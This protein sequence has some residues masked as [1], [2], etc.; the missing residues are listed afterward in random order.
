[1]PISFKL[2]D[3]TEFNGRIIGFSPYAI[4]ITQPNGV[5]MTIQKLALAYYTVAQ[6]EEE[7][8]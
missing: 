1:M 7:A 4:T 3:G 5:E 6:T 2:F 8:A